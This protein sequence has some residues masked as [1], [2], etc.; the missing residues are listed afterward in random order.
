MTIDNPLV[1]RQKAA[2]TALGAESKKRRSP[3]AGGF[4]SSK[5]FSIPFGCDVF[6]LVSR[7]SAKR[8]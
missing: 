5:P 4:N 1:I 8:Y 6:V 7:H 2:T 3:R